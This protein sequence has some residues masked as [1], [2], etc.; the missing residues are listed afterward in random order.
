[1][2]VLRLGD[3][4]LQRLQR[5]RALVARQHARLLQIGQVLAHGVGLRR[6]R[7]GRIGLLQRQRQRQ[8]KEESEHHFSDSISTSISGSYS[9]RSPSSSAVISMV[10][11]L[12]SGT[13]TMKLCSIS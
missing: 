1:Q 12:P 13:L 8:T 7:R 2:I 5:R 6:R 9:G 3:R 11:R 10:V 4:L